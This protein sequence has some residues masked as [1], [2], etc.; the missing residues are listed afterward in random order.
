MTHEQ[1][2][3]A[4]RAG[5]GPGA[6]MAAEQMWR[7]VSEIVDAGEARMHAAVSG[8]ADGWQGG[9]GD[10][11]RSGLHHLN[12]WALEAATDARNTVTAILDQGVSAGRLR[13]SLPAP[14]TA[15]LD[16]AR[17]MAVTYPFD[18][19]MQTALADAEAE[20][21]WREESARR[22][23]EGYHY[24]SMDNR[25]LMDYWT[26][27]PTV[28]VEGLPA[29]GG[30]GGSPAG[31]SGGA[32]GLG[33]GGL[34]AGG[35]GAGGL[36]AAGLGTAVPVDGASGG[37]GSGAAGSG[38]PV[39]GGAGAVGAG[40]A[41]GIGATGASSAPP[42]AAAGAGLAP[43]AGISG[44]V[45]P[46]GAAPGSGPAG[47]LRAGPAT[48]GPGAVPTVRGRADLP[49]GAGGRGPRAAPGVSTPYGGGVRPV[50]PRAP[51]PS[52]PQATWRDVVAG[53]RLA[54][55]AVRGAAPGPGTRPELRTAGFAA[56]G[57]PAA[58]SA[59]GGHGLYPP[60]AGAGG[61]GAGEGRRRASYLIDDSG[62]FEV[63]VPHT[64]P[65]IGEGDR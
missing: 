33:A 40:A 17:A 54:D 58:R 49:A 62:A 29:S 26:V 59:V 28:L 13:S 16:D 47:A 50:V 6:S 51:T 61:G 32:G 11:A 37:S 38:G 9:A 48:G 19:D 30:G 12:S 42:A 1:L 18:P 25:R 43:G 34:G 15:Q 35:L 60:M 46:G 10:A 3:A 55:P 45:V 39:P 56:P 52:G 4:V 64:E 44:G 31:G 5:P 57:E 65:V 24:H 21:V 36:G 14:N 7:R 22:A 2:D 20:A 41:G 23:M 8:S 63:D 27:P 53:G